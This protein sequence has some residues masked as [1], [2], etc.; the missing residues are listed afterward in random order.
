MPTESDQ[1]MTMQEFIDAR[2]AEG[3]SLTSAVGQVVAVSAASPRA[4]WSWLKGERSEPESVR[5]LLQ[6]WT[7]CSPEQRRRWFPTP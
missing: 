3:M 6:I 7:E 1:R 2:Q 5:R 4:V